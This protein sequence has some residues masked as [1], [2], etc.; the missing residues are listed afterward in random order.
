LLFFF[1]TPISRQVYTEALKLHLRASPLVVP[2]DQAQLGLGRIV[3]LY[4]RS[5]SLYWI[6]Y[7]IRYLFF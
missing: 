5:S 7:H 2:R 4:H 1:L 3:A 6:H